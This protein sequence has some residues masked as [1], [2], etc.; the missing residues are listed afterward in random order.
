MLIRRTDRPLRAWR[1]RSLGVRLPRGRLRADTSATGAQ[2]LAF[3]GAGK[4]LI[5]ADNQLLKLDPGTAT[6]TKIAG[7]PGVI[8]PQF[9]FMSGLATDSAGHKRRGKFA[10]VR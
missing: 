2:Q 9:G 10:I 7:S 6:L 1:W 4:L 5:L 3:D 8:T